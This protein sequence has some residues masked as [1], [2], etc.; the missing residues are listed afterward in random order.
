MEQVANEAEFFTR[1]A[2]F[3]YLE[4]E[5]RIEILEKRLSR[6]RDRLDYL[7]KLQ[8]MADEASAT[9]HAQRV[10]AFHGQQIRNEYQWIASWLEEMRA[11]E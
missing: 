10:L 5:E 7:S 9:A 3:D 8:Q 2:F 4:P 1:V 11:S 6:V